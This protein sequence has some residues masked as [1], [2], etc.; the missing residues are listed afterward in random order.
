MTTNRSPIPVNSGKGS[1]G[2]TDMRGGLSYPLT[3]PV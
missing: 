3:A 2:A 1:R